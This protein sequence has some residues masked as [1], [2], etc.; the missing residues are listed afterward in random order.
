MF[1]VD[2]LTADISILTLLIN[3]ELEISVLV[4]YTVKV[5]THQR[6]MNMNEKNLLQCYIYYPKLKY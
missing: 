4:I 3:F 6:M 2:N 1:L 5:F